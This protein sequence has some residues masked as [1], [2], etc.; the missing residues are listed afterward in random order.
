[1]RGKMKKFVS[2]QEVEQVI[3]L[4]E[5]MTERRRGLGDEVKKYADENGYKSIV[6]KAWF[7][8]KEGVPREM[9]VKIREE[10]PK[11]VLVE[12]LDT[13]RLKAEERHS[14][15][16]VPIMEENGYIYYVSPVP[17]WLPKSVVEEGL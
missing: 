12:Y 6:I 11:A 5:M 9:Y 2:E 1:M 14:E 13:I 10:R 8:K 3:G 16:Y 7:A 17:Q 4:G 15:T